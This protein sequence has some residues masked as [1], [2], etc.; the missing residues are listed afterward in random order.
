MLRS[1]GQE[2]INFKKWEKN[3]EA[4]RGRIKVL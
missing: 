2:K 4:L 3:K 1:R